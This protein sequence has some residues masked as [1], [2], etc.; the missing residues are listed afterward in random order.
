MS[1]RPRDRRMAHNETGSRMTPHRAT[2]ILALSTLVLAG[3]SAAGGHAQR[4]NNLVVASEPPVSMPRSPAP[5]GKTLP[6][7]AFELAS[8]QQNVI[9][10]A[11]TLLINQCG[12]RFGFDRLLSDPGAPV[13]RDPMAR[14]YG[15]V[16][17]TTARTSGYH[18]PASIGASRGPGSQETAPMT[19]TQLWVLIGDSTDTGGPPPDGV[20][21]QSGAARPAPSSINGIA[22]PPGGC[23]GEAHRTLGIAAIPAPSAELAA[24]LDTA[25]FAQMERDSRVRAVYRA[26]SACMAALGYKYKDVFDPVDNGGFGAA[27]QPTE[28][29]INTAVADVGCKQQNNVVGTMFA[30]ESAYQ[31]VLV[32][33]N[34]ETLTQTKRALDAAVRKAAELL[35]I[36]AP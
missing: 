31:D 36:A 29:E 19:Q 4:P 9:E 12:R 26:W 13:N 16:D 15:V 7:A 22:I 11:N 33:Q 27:G 1:A 2:M 30:V 21:G 18:P 6:L 3:C 8:V 14:R 20:A 23:T 24:T 25:G 35:G 10:R 34:L 17:L 5:T 28:L 32:Q